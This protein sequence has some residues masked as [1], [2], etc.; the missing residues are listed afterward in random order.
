[1][2]YRAYCNGVHAGTTLIGVIARLRQVLIEPGRGVSWCCTQRRSLGAS[3]TRFW[4][5]GCCHLSRSPPAT[6]DGQ[7]SEV[8][9]ATTGGDGRGRGPAIS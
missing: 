8:D 9:N 3:H 5:R 6:A 2:Y 1:M 7:S 4:V